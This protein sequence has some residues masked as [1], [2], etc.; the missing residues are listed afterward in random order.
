[1]KGVLNV[2]MKKGIITI[3]T[4]AVVILGVFFAVRF[5][6]GSGDTANVKSPD[7]SIVQRDNS[8]AKGN[9]E[10]LVNEESILSTSETQ[11][12]AENTQV[13]STN[14]MDVAYVNDKT[15]VGIYTVKKN[16]TVYS[17]ARAYMPSHEKDKIV[18]FIKNR[19]NMNELY[20]IKE[21]DKIVIPYEKAFETSATV[22]SEVDTSKYTIKENDTLTSIAKS[23]MPSY[24]AKH[25]IEML[26]EENKITNENDIKAGTVINIP[27]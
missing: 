9:S 15:D 11:N 19:N 22:A 14:K 3:S 10:A 18:D 24:N 21:G 2:R 23:I 5:I 8:I 4:I 27:K 1:M 7:D 26:K 25:A 20:S 16:D 13:K 12:E 6:G 17:I